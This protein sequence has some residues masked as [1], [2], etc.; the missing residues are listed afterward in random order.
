MGFGPR[1]SKVNPICTSTAEAVRC[2]L[3]AAEFFRS[4]GFSVEVGHGAGPDLFCEAGNLSYTVEVKKAGLN[5]RRWRV[6]NVKPARKKDDLV[7]IVLPNGRVYIDSMEHH[8]D[9]CT[10][11]DGSRS[12]TR[13][14]KEFGLDKT[15]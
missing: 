8:L 9:A 12:V 2:E 11:R 15:L 7:A 10:P 13:I 4:L 5:S 14:V 6:G 1:G 3:V